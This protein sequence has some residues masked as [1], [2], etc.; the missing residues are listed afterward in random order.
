MGETK[1][2]IAQRT[3]TPE[4]PVIQIDGEARLLNETKRNG[5]S[6]KTTTKKTQQLSLRRE[7]PAQQKEKDVHIKKRN[8]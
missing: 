2:E 1:D 5:R 7:N 8:I 3:G 6:G 4:N